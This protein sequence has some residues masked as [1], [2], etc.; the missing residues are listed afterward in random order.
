MN[1]CRTTCNSFLHVS[2]THKTKKTGGL[3]MKLVG[4]FSIFSVLI[5][6]VCF[7]AINVSAQR[8][9]DVNSGTPTS[10]KSRVPEP[11]AGAGPQLIQPEELVNILKS[12][13]GA[14]PLVIQ[15][16]FRVLYV[17]A[18]IPGSEY[19]GPA[20]GEE[21]LQQLRKRVAAL[22]HTHF[23]VLYCGCCPWGQCPNVNPAYQEMRA[24]GFTNVKVLYI[25]DNFGK[26]WVN[27]GYPVAR[28]E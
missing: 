3:V 23:I 13:N 25:A 24:M 11:S 10:A 14:K 12:A 6:F 19:V 20:S 16:G 4:A 8:S 28:G 17:Q 21:G 22:P 2:N 27:K 1:T 9:A 26:D 18:H 15:V 5:A 7:S